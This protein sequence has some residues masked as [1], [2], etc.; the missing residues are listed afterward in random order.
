MT[1]LNSKELLTLVVEDAEKEPP[2]VTF[3][4]FVRQSHIKHFI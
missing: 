1:E 2:F 3:F 4:Y